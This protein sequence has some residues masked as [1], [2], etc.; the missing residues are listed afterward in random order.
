MLKRLTC[1]SLVYKYSPFKGNLDEYKKIL[2]GKI[3]YDPPNKDF[4]NFKGMLKLK[5]DPIS[6]E[7]TINNLALKGSTLNYSD[8]VI[9]LVVYI[10][11][12]V[13]VA[14][15]FSPIQWTESDFFFDKFPSFL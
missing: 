8:W 10:G 2:T 6:E 11:N 7:L 4:E 1:F 13:K 14:N 3:Q 5:K 9:G 12:E 15:E